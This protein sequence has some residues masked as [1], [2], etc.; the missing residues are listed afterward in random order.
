[1]S[2]GGVKN[3]FRTDVGTDVDIQKISKRTNH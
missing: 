2:V 1:M 3:E